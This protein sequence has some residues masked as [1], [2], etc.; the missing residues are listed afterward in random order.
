[1]K[2]PLNFLKKACMFRDSDEIIL[3][4]EPETDTS[5]YDVNI[6]SYRHRMFNYFTDIIFTKFTEELDATYESYHNL[7]SMHEGM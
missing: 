5:I 7:H 6:D 3:I 1:M 4:P 2:K